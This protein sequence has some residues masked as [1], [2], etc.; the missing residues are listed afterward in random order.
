MQYLKPANYS[1]TN[2]YADVPN[3]TI[4]TIYEPG[5]GEKLISAQISEVGAVNGITVKV[6]ASNDDATYVDITGCDQNGTTLGAADV[7]LAASG[8]K[9]I[10]I[11]PTTAMAAFRFYKLQ[12]K[13]TIG[14]DAGTLASSIAAK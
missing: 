13:S 3:S 6:V 4:D 1:T 11:A 14:G 12:A 8:K 2:S 5:K 7:T 10:V 9:V